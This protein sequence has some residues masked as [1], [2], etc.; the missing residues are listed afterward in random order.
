VFRKRPCTRSEEQDEQRNKQAAAGA[1]K[2]AAAGGRKKKVAGVDY[3]VLDLEW[4][5][6]LSPQR[7][8]REPFKLGGEIIQFG[9]VKIDSLDDLNITDRYSEM[10]KPVFYT[11]MHKRVTE[12]TELTDADLA[13]GRPFTEVCAEFLEW[14]GDDYAFIT[15]GESD[16]FMLEDNMSIHDMD[17]D[18]LPECYDA[19]VVF[20]DQITQEDRSFAL[21]YA[22]WKF[23]IKPER[24][25]DALNDAVNTVEVMKRLDFS[26]GLEG[27]EV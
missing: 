4:N 19:Q 7:M 8:V 20:D 26:E 3:I 25:H 12:V 5:Q 17:I 15:W 27:Y 6:A 23:G 11:K 22:M 18:M 9:A 1:D 24:S 13:T 16:I 2:G 10:V 21:S 14:C